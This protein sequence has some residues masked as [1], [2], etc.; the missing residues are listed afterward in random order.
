[1]FLF[2][3]SESRFLKSWQIDDIIDDKYCPINT[4]LMIECK[5]ISIRP[6]NVISLANWDSEY[7]KIGAEM[8]HSCA[9]PYCADF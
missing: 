6:S 1:M 4:A 9:L 5:Q 7:S 2:L 8:W 3:V